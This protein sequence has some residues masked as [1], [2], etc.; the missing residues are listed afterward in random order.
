MRKWFI[1]FQVL[2]CRRCSGVRQRALTCPECGDVPDEREVDQHLARRRRIVERARR[3][4]A[5]LSR[6][7]VEAAA[8]GDIQ[9]QALHALEG[10]FGGIDAVL[11]ADAEDDA[12]TI[13]GQR[14]AMVARLRSQL[15]ATPRRR[16][17]AAVWDGTD[18]ALTH[19]GTA[20]DLFVQALHE[21]DMG[22]AQR[23]ATEAQ[24]RLDAASSPLAAA[25]D[26][27]SELAAALE[28]GSAQILG[29]LAYRTALRSSS[30]DVGGPPDPYA[31]FMEEA[32]LSDDQ[33]EFLLAFE[34]E[35]ARVFFDRS[36]FWSLAGETYRQVED[37]PQLW[38][39][40][41]DDAWRKRF[42]RAS[43]QVAD[44]GVSAEAMATA[45]Y[46]ERQ[47]VRVDLEAIK[48]LLEGPAK[49]L[50][51]TRLCLHRRRPFA[52][53]DGYASAI[54]Q[55]AEQAGMH[56]AT[57]GL[58]KDLR[59]AISHEDFDVDQG[60]LVLGLGKTSEQRIERD[61][62]VD[63][64]LA[65]L[66]TTLAMHTA[67]TVLL[68][69]FDEE[70]A[71]EAGRRAISPEQAVWLCFRLLE[72]DVT[73][74][75]T[76]DGKICVVL[77]NPF[78]SRTLTGV[79]SLTWLLPGE[80]ETLE[81]VSDVDGRLVGP[82]APFRAFS[83]EKDD[84]KRDL[85]FWDILTTWCWNDERLAGHTLWR[86]WV[87]T[88]AVQSLDDDPRS[89][90]KR[91]RD[92]RAFADKLRDPELVVLVNDVLRFHQHRLTRLPMAEGDIM[93]MMDRLR[94]WGTRPKRW[95][96]LIQPS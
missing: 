69:R 73:A 26:A 65:A 16:P 91:L 61:E 59:D 82:L 6:G 19:L 7:P 48:T 58:R 81:L 15:S 57:L 14:L 51:R 38:S 46:H 50:L 23:R 93:R 28:G 54:I 66:E 94:T 70:L 74:A 52:R 63:E 27:L 10:L 88:I 56:A 64:L 13:L 34:D 92:L 62:L 22:D 30:D 75:T 35:R 31:A 90:I 21:A 53:V 47:L 49:T 33:F 20:A 42:L 9:T 71:G 2:E 44:I 77:A 8:L 3:I 86:F 29:W 4:A 32:E 40:F 17:F 78:D 55:Q 11:G 18:H 45:A 80:S 96:K 76:E 12:A 1:P 72:Y 89:A 83:S 60:T 67:I 37:S 84:W 24:D 95:P 68:C 25:T 85:N 41:Q 79:A 87:S 36:R 5:D 43:E 39:L